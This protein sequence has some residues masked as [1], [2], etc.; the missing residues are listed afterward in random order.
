MKTWP[1]FGESK[2]HL[3][4]AGWKWLLYFGVKPIPNPQKAPQKPASE[5][6]KLPRNLKLTASEFAPENRPW[7]TPQK[8]INLPTIG[9]ME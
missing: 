2:G 5:S 3:E 4:E 1:P 6:P 8:E 9:Q 7:K